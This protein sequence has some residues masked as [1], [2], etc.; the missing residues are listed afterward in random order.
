MENEVLKAIK[1]RRSIRRFKADQITDEE[2]KTVLE[3]GTWAA[4]GHGTQEPFIIAVQNPEI[5]AQL[6]KMNAEIM[7]VESDPYYG[8]PTIVIVLAPESN[9]NGV[10]DGSLILGNMMLA[11]HSIGLASCWINREDGMFASEE[12][13]RLM[14]DWN[15][16][17][18]LMGVGA[19]ALGYA[20]AHP[21][22]V[23]PRKEDYYRIIK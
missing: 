13:K 21:H 20:S 3:A 19:L 18:G 22:T 11:A 14:K 10:K 6:R 2:L 16:P 23:K 5:C 15:L 7:G 1:E 8:A 9:V 17:E 4:T 12:G